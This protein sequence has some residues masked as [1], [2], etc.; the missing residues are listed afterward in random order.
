MRAFV[1]P[2][3]G[4]Q[5]IGMGKD[6]AAAYPAAKAV[7]E[8]DDAALGERMRDLIWDGW[9]RWPL[10]LVWIW[11]RSKRWQQR[12]RRAR[13]VRRLMTMIPHRWLFRATRPQLNVRLISPRPKAPNARCCYLSAHPFIAA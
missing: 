5:T 8:E 12:P 1:F 6:L 7:F 10:S 4:A 9:V 3:Q 13:F 2:G 11:R